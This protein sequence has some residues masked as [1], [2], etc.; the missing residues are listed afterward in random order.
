MTAAPAPAALPPGPR[1]GWLQAARYVA[2]PHPLLRAAAARYGA[3]FTIRTARRCVMTGRPALVRQIFSAPVDQYAVNTE[4]G[5]RRVLG[6]NGMAQQSGRAL[7]RDRRL[8]L[9]NFQGAALTG[10]AG[11]MRDAAL[12]VAEGWTPGQVVPMREAALAIALDI[13]LRTVFGADTPAQRIEFRA[14]LRDF[15]HAFTRPGFL[16]CSAL[17][18]EQE[19]LP[20]FRRFAAARGRLEGL[21]RQAIAR[22]RQDGPARGDVLGRLVA[23]RHEDGSA[24]PEAALVDNLITTAIAGHET[25]VVSLCWALH[26]LHSEPDCLARLLAELA[27]LGPDPDPLA[28]A[29]L[30]YLDAVVREVLRLWPAVTDVNRVLARPMQLG[31][32]E[33]PAGMTVAA[34][35]AI[36]HYD[37]D[38][39]PEPDRF[40]PERFLETRFAPWEYIPFGGGERLCPGAQF[41]IFEL[42]LLLGVLLARCRFTA[43]AP[44]DP[45]PKRVGFLVS[46]RD[47]VPLRYEGRR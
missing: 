26:W 21:L 32:W 25:S 43:L 17:H 10:L 2:A 8:L 4:A 36:L 29:G 6:A 14:A 1:L 46:P 27:P 11:M 23:A 35:A 12:E 24:M 39:Y 40:R 37:P 34:A 38:L 31:G 22:A 41:S 30:P 47:G 16:L 5:P 20:P 18:V 3:V 28:V 13:I 33:I 44:G 15:D 45:R 19:W 42:K 9:P 7:R